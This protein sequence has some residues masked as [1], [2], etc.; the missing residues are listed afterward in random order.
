MSIH[1]HLGVVDLPYDNA[2]GA[3]TG[4]VAGWLED[5]YHVMEVFYQLHGRQI[6]GSLENSLAGALENLLMGAPA[7]DAEFG[8][9]TSA[10]EDMF[11]KFLESKEMDGLGIPGVPTQASLR[12]ISKRF[13]SKRGSPRPSFIDSAMYENSFTAWVEQT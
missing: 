4:D 5:D 1:L 2:A 9:A 13:K 6:A 10:I 12:G 3:S 11:R 7:N 8:G